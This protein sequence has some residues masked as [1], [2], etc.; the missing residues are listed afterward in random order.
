MPNYII[1][2]NEDSNGFNEVHDISCG[3][4]PLIQNQVSIGWHSDAKSAVS[5]AK[6]NG[7]KH[8]DGCYYCCEEAHHG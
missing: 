6:I 8:A 5:Y 3:H 7:W 4:L 1:N 2:K